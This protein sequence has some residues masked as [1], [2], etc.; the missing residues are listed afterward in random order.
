MVR[1]ERLRWILALPV[2][3]NCSGARGN[4]KSHWLVLLIGAAHYAD[5][6][7]ISLFSRAGA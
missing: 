3:G 1:A 5:I 4:G 2:H 6:S 7:K